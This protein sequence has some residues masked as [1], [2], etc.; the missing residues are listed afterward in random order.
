MIKCHRVLLITLLLIV[1]SVTFQ[2]VA[3]AI[4]II[5]SIRKLN[6]QFEDGRY[7]IY[8]YVYFSPV[9]G[10]DDAVKYPLT[11]WL[12]GKGSGKFARAQLQWYEF[13]NWS[14][15][16]YQARFENAWTIS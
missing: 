7:S 15:D 1:A 4:P 2:F 14:S 3:S 16:N 6:N 10:E 8:D 9:D 5:S 13:C 11:I 12:H